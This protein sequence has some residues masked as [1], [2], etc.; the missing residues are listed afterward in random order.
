L[1]SVSWRVILPV[2]V[3]GRARLAS[4]TVGEDMAGDGMGCREEIVYMCS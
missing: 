1:S 4:V 3:L 2:L